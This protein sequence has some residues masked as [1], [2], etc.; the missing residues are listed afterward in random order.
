MDQTAIRIRPVWDD[1]SGVVDLIRSAGPFWPLANYAAS[2]AE[3]AALGRERVSFTPP[4]FRQDFARESQ[5]LVPGADALLANERF[6]H[7]AH[8]LVG[9]VG[10]VVRPQAV[11]VNVMA[12]TP[13]SFPPHLDIPAFRGFTRATQPVWLLKTMKTSGLF[14][15]WRT[16][17]ATAVTWFYDGVGGDFHYWPDG[18]NGPMSVERSPYGNVCVLADNEVTFHGVSA[19]GDPGA[20]MPE[21][22]NRESRLVRGESDWE[23]HDADGVN[24]AHFSDDEVR[25]T[26]SWKADLFANA[27]EAA[28]HDAGDNALALETVVELFQR[29]LAARGIEL[30][31]ASD[32]LADQRWIATLA[33]T[34]QD[35][36]PQMR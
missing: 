24:Q 2:D 30:G 4:W 13:F 15:E 3:M 6:V 5:V 12:P 17:I 16:K 25:I 8:Q 11:Y 28:M 9:G 35:S 20:D 14:E 22:L 1:P 26:V 31:V 21:G 33:S 34:Y 27:E 36:A 19:L 10:A 29:D 7:G 18:P 32:P 23:V